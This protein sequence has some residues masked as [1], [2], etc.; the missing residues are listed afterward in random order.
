MHKTSLVVDDRKL[1]RARKLLGTRG[2][3]DTIDRALDEVI[4]QQARLEA[5][6]RLRRL[7]GLD[8]DLLLRVRK[9]AWR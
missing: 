6:E 3:R 2:I 8:K 7:E 1:A 4:A 9:E 5:W